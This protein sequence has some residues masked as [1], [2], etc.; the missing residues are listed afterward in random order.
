[1][2]EAKVADGTCTVQVEGSLL[3]IMMDV[4]R[5]VGAVY[6]SMKKTNP[7][8]AEAYK[9]GI[10]VSVKDDS[11]VWRFMEDCTEGTSVIIQ[12]PQKKGG[13][14]TGQS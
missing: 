1:M 10:I 7:I 11:P 9:A 8:D 14:P 5:A 13:A 2:F 3:Q 6:E 12:T 4:A